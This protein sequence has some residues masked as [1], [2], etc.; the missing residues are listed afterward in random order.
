MQI[1][2]T[3]I[4]LTALANVALAGLFAVIP[5]WRKAFVSKTADEQTAIFGLVSIGLGI[6]LMVGTCAGSLTG[7]ACTQVEVTSYFVGVVLSSISGIQAA[8]AAFVGVRLIDSHGKSGDSAGRSA[9]I[10]HAGRSK[11]LD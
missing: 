7:I 10:P 3:P 6:V 2:L 8:K 5:P 4:A 1:P 9:G 11:M